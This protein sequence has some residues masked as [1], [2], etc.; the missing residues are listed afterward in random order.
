M[1]CLNYITTAILMFICTFCFNQNGII[2]FN[3]KQN[4][5]ELQNFETLI[6]I[7]MDTLSGS[8]YFAIINATQVPSQFIAGLQGHNSFD[9]RQGLNIAAS[10]INSYDISSIHPLMIFN[11]RI[12]NGSSST[13]VQNRLLFGWANR[14]D[15]KM[16]MS[17]EGR[18]GIGNI[19]PKSKL[20]ISEGDVFIE[21]INRGII[22]KSPD[23]NCWRYTPDNS[24]ALIGT[25]ISCP[26]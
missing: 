8:D 2:E 9:D 10:T 11:S 13:N 6:S 3:G 23:G 7:K 14:L 20:Q 12:R 18:L 5:I 4:I 1:Q 24:G 21:D 26:N 15:M 25:S 22:M 19:D 17:Q 16:V